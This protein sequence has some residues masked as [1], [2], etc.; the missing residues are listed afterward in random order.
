MHQLIAYYY[1]QLSFF[2]IRCGYPCA[3]VLKVTNEL[4]IDMI[5]VEHWKLYATHS[6]NE[7]LG[8]GWELKKM[9]LQYIHYEGLGVPMMKEILDRCQK[10]SNDD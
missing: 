6:N 2:Y 9:Q 7:S 3:H 4:S 1:S 8:I 10:P 5:K